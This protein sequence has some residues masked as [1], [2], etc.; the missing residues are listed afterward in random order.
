MLIKIMNRRRAKSRKV[1]DLRR[2]M[3]YLFTPKLSAEP[4]GARLLGPPE[5]HQLLLND[6]PWGDEVDDAA[7]DLADQLWRY[8]REARI[9]QSMPIVWYVHV[10]CSFAPAATE[11]LRSPPDPYPT[12]ARWASTAKNAIRVTSDAMDFLG[13][14]LN[15]P[16]VFV[17]HGD[18]EHIHVHVVAAIPTAG[19]DDWAILRL[20]RREI[21]KVA[22]ICAEAFNIPVAPRIATSY[23]GAWEAIHGGADDPSGHHS[24]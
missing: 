14:T 18:R 7:F 23:Y 3:R 11:S 5:L 1:G 20:S 24:V 9:G 22:K 6:R 17:V 21:N 12:P 19:D 10:I 16:S 15:R 4:M 8:C 13:W 2:L